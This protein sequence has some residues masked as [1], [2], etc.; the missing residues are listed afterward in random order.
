MNL[1]D[2]LDLCQDKHSDDWVEVPEE[3]PAT[4]MLGRA[5]GSHLAVYEPNPALSMLWLVSED[6]DEDFDGLPFWAE[7]DTHDWHGR[8]GYVVILL[9]GAPVWQ[10]QSW[11]MTWGSAVGG[12]VPDIRKPMHD[13]GEHG[14][15]ANAEWTT[16][17]WEAS[18]ARL[19]NAV[20]YVS[21]DW[22]SF[23]PVFRLV[24]EPVP[25]HPLGAARRE[26]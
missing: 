21:D 23:D 12:Y 11:Y 9:N 26:Y 1:S 2:L 8:S 24:P 13:G 16:T 5:F 10:T 22:H 20:A 25:I 14:D 17:K 3:R 6:P 18:L 7:E 15:P 4:L 19:L